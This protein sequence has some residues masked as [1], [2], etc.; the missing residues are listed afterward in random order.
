MTAVTVRT[1]RSRIGSAA[2]CLA[3]LVVATLASASVS[4]A[5]FTAQPQTTASFA[6]DT[7]APPT[8]LSAVGGTTAVLSWT[9]TVQTYATGYHV[10][11]AA[12][13]AGPYALLATVTPRTTTTYTDAPAV[14]TYYYTV[15]AYYQ[16]WESVDAGPVS[17][18]VVAA[19]PIS[20]GYLPCSSNAADTSGAGDNNG[21]EG[22]SGNACLGGATPATDANSGT[23]T[24]TSCGSG[25]T[26]STS[27]DRHRFWGYALGLPVVVSAIGGIQVRAD[28][29]LNDTIGTTNLCS[30][31]SWDGGATWT[32]I[33]TQAITSASRTTYIFGT[34]A[35]LWG[36]AWTLAQLT[37][38]SLRVRIIDASSR[39]S[40]QFNL[41]YV[42]VQVTYTP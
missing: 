23:S 26:P 25:A 35:D 8:A 1:S 13:L 31:L 17:A 29:A 21:Y 24:S 10:Y 30:Q 38:T 28:L 5:A 20:T 11:R 7:L 6:T 39:S 19:G 36:H 34:T 27:K 42:A 33:K 37:S 32:T 3:L 16:S 9:A 15:R 14:G 41:Y 12:A 4:L 2:A 18:V 40:K 22:S